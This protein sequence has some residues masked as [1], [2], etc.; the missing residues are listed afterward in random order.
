[1]L[2]AIAFIIVCILHLSQCN[3]DKT[4]SVFIPQ[5]SS[6]AHVTIKHYKPASTPFEIHSKPDVK[7]P[8]NISELNVERIVKITPSLKYLLLLGGDKV[9]VINM[10]ETKD[11]SIYIDTAQVKNIE[12]ICYDE[13]ILRFGSF[14]FI[15]ITIANHPLF[16]L[17][18][19]LAFS[20]L[21]VYGIVQLP[22]LLIDV[23][24][25]GG[26]IACRWKS[27]SFGLLLHL[28]SINNH[29]FKLSLTYNL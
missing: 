6:F 5:D 17:T 29:Q 21:Q 3:N 28:S 4:S 9:G 14:F 27:L 25:V 26:G 16:Y 8:K 23:Q 10:I 19:S 15:G 12:M 1:M 18:P 7:L 24:G 22:L 13:P 20:P 2:I 11:G